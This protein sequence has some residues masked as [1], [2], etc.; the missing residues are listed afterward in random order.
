M[1]FKKTKLT[2]ICSK[3]HIITNIRNYILANFSN[4]MSVSSGLPHR[5]DECV[6][7]K[8]AFNK[9]ANSK[10][11]QSFSFVILAKSLKKMIL[12]ASSLFFLSRID[13]RP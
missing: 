12:L 9:L 6:A 5:E 8:V 1:T 4:Y 2:L 3:N 13:I 10:G 7:Y 11:V